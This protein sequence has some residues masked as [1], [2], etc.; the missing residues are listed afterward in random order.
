MKSLKIKVCG[1]R[2]AQNIAD[3]LELPIDYIG[4]IFYE[5]SLRYVALT[6]QLINSIKFT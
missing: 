2:D 6:P 3:L 4:F 5:K 1:M